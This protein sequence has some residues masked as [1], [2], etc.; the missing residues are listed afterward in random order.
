MNRHEATHNLGF[1]VGRGLRATVA[2]G[3]FSLICGAPPAAAEAPRIKKLDARYIHDT[4]LMAVG[5]GEP[6]KKRC[7]AASVGHFAILTSYHC[8]A[9]WW[10]R[11]HDNPVRYA[12]DENRKY[13]VGG[14]QRAYRSDDS[15]KWALLETG[16]QRGYFGYEN[17]DTA[18]DLSSATFDLVG[19]SRGVKG[20]RELAFQS[21]CRLSRKEAGVYTS[22]CGRDFDDSGILILHKSAQNHAVNGLAFIQSQSKIGK[23]VIVTLAVTSSNGYGSKLADLRR[24][25]Q[26]RFAPIAARLNEVDATLAAERE[27]TRASKAAQ[28]KADLDNLAIALGQLG[29]ALGGARQQ[30]PT[31]VA[32]TYGTAVPTRS[33]GGHCSLMLSGPALYSQ[34]TAVAPS[35]GGT[36]QLVVDTPAGCWWKFELSSQTGGAWISTLSPLNGTGRGVLTFLTTPHPPDESISRLLYFTLSVP[37]RPGQ[38]AYDRNDEFRVTQCAPGVRPRDC[39]ASASTSQ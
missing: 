11:Q 37:P 14:F 6:Q 26:N 1:S 15:S 17:L 38:P 31:P 27:A 24:D 8:L 30:A 28:R 16:G 7:V 21:P 10:T 33:P 20:G 22:E 9:D 18:V 29:G 34:K 19:F 3:L 39:G 12:S 2:A 32:P 23:R 36:I 5:S 4:R 35:G 13:Y 25:Q